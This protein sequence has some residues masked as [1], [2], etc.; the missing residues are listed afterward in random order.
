MHEY[1]YFQVSL[2]EDAR[3]RLPSHI[4][5]DINDHIKRIKEEVGSSCILGQ[6][7]VFESNDGQTL[8]II[9]SVAWNTKDEIR[10]VL[11]G[12]PVL[13]PSEREAFM[14]NLKR[15][16]G[17]SNPHILDTKSDEE[18]QEK[19]TPNDDSDESEKPEEETHD[20]GQ[21]TANE[22]IG[23]P[24][25]MTTVVGPNGEPVSKRVDELKDDDV[26]FEPKSYNEIGKE[27]QDKDPN[28][29]VDS[30]T[31]NQD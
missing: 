20:D 28:V 18:E 13:L 23:V 12:G 11:D 4:E 7:N 8:R 30:L 22:E 17:V 15:E 26:L 29:T 3:S 24:V 10:D 6:M 25:K 9:V 1:K 21:D 31:P 19:Q 5:N 16:E 27:G 14:E 2:V